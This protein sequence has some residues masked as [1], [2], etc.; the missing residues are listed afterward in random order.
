MSDSLDALVYVVFL[1]KYTELA[2][3]TLT[4]PVPIELLPP[5]G[6]LIPN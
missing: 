6:P 5:L 2:K 1:H 3:G 4:V